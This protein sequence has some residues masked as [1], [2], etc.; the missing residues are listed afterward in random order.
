MVRTIT[1]RAILIVLAGVGAIVLGV[2]ALT[3]NATTNEVYL[4]WGEV[5]AGIGL[6]LGVVI[7]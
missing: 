3:N 2:L 6:I 5:S 7:L 4:G 1:L